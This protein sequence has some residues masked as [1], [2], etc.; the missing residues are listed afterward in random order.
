[1]CMYDKGCQSRS[2]GFGHSVCQIVLIP[3]STVEKAFKCGCHLFLRKTCFSYGYMRW[4]CNEEGRAGATEQWF[5]NC[6]V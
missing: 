3:S 5:S 1:M 6:A 2:Q 4:F